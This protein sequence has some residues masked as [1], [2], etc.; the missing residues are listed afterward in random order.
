MAGSGTSRILR[1]FVAYVRVDLTPGV[2][3]GSSGAT[4]FGELRISDFEGD[5]K[6]GKEGVRSMVFVDMDVGLSM[7]DS[8]FERLSMRFA[9]FEGDGDGAA[10]VMESKIRERSR[11]GFG[12]ASE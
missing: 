7:D 3:N 9:S 12:E 6:L 11:V 1:N 5:G 10:G 2:S 4:G 8:V